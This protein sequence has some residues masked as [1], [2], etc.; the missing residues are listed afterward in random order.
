MKKRVVL[1]IV[2]IGIA[3]MML[4]GCQAKKLTLRD[5][6]RLSEKG[7]ALTWSDFENYPSIDVGSGLYIRVYDIDDTF[8]LGIGGGS[9]DEKP[10]YIRLTVKDTENSIDIREEDVQAFIDQYQH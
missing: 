7:D 8:S 5:V 4:A 6:V 10:M 3:L 2:L 1:S 9:V